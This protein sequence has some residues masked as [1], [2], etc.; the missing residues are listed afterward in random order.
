MYLDAEQT[1]WVVSK[2]IIMYAQE[3]SPAAEYLDSPLTRDMLKLYQQELYKH[4]GCVVMVTGS[5]QSRTPRS[6][7]RRRSIWTAC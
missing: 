2:P 7:A 3:R 6:V 5:P 4:A 1:R